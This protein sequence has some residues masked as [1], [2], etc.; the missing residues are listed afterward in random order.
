MIQPGQ[1]QTE[2]IGWLE[3]ADRRPWWRRLISKLIGSRD[4]PRYVVYAR[5]EDNHFPWFMD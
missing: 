4:R 5:I 2:V 3:M 1:D